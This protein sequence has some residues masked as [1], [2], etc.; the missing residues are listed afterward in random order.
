MKYSGFST[1]VHKN[2]FAV[3]YLYYCNISDN[4]TYLP[5]HKLF[6]TTLYNE[7]SIYFNASRSGSRPPRKYYKRFQHIEQDKR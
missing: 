3:P 1:I 2:V 6:E 5:A 7:K 4:R